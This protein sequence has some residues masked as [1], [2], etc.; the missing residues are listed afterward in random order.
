VKINTLKGLS[1]EFQCLHIVD[2]SSRVRIDLL[3]VKQHML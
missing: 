3:T 1:G 2:V